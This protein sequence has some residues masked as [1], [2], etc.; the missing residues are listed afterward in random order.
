MSKK[1]LLKSD[2]FAVANHHVAVQ[3]FEARTRRGG[4]RYSAE[5]LLDSGEHI[6]LDGDS[7]KSLEIRATRLVP[8]TIYSRRLIAA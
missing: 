7:V 6:I 1:T 8:A 3:Y 5:I 2:D 4:R